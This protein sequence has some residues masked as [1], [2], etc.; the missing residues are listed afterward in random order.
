MLKISIITISYNN[1]ADIRETI[2]SVTT[3]QYEN[4]EYIVVDGSSSDDTMNIVREYSDSITTIISEPDNGMY[5][6]INKG[7]QNAT[8]DVIGLIHAG[9]RLHDSE[10]IQKIADHFINNPK[11]N[12]MHGDSKVVTP[13]GELKRVNIGGEFSKKRIKR[14]WMPP[15]QSIYLKKEVFEKFGLYRNDLGGAGDYEFFIRVFY[16][17]E[18]NIKYLNE[19]ITYF[20]TGGNSTKS[21]W[22]KLKYQ[23]I[24]MNCWR[25]NDVDPPLT[26]VAG[27]I[28]RK[29]PMLFKALKIQLYSH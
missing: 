24:H 28:I 14:G 26:L 21:I 12:A 4:I 23:K 25:L 20:T 22:L 17:Q 8:G 27:K 10:V 7:I 1:E 18:L 16:C 6:A 9:D 5:D 19:F 3:Q 2:E 29:L 13:G 15:H 11:I